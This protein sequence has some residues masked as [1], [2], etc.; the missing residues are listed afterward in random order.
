MPALFGCVEQFSRSRQQPFVYHL[1][2]QNCGGRR[3]QDH[4]VTR[5]INRPD[6]V[7][8]K[9]CLHRTRTQ[10]ATSWSYKY[11]NGF[12]SPVSL[13]SRGAEWAA[14]S[15][16]HADR[17]WRTDWWGGRHGSWTLEWIWMEPSGLARTDRRTLTGGKEPMRMWKWVWRDGHSD[18]SW[19]REAASPK[20][21]LPTDCCT[22]C[23][24]R[25]KGVWNLPC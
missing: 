18:V 6:V 22:C 4:P 8:Q 7:L 23:K 16:R 17:C 12:S 21:K 1:A 20:E 11:E 25:F 10:R 9:G 3:S 14:Y 24:A 13:N 15:N 5:T 2:I 19:E